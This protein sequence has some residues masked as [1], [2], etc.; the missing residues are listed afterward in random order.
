M[1]FAV[2]D[3]QAQRER[4]CVTMTAIVGIINKHAVAMADD[5]AVTIHFSL[6]K[7]NLDMLVLLLEK[8]QG[9]SFFRY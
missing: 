8:N 4:R 9:Q 5:S 1:Y 2:D 6:S 7:H 3:V